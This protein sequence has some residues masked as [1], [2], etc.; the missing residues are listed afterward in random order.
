MTNE[1]LIE[2]WPGYTQQSWQERFQ[3]LDRRRDEASKNTM[4]MVLSFSAYIERLT[5]QLAEARQAERAAV[6]AL[7]TRCKM[8]GT[9]APASF[10]NICNRPECEWREPA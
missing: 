3:E 9:A 7:G 5:A 2:R 6:V 1:E 8:C 4:A 10:A